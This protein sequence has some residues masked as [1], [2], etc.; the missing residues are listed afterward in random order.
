MSTMREMILKG[1]NEYEVKC[2]PSDTP[3]VKL[4]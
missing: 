4:G 1:E 3:N 2:I